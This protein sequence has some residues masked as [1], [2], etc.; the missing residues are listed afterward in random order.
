MLSVQEGNKKKHGRINQED[1]CY[2]L[3]GWCLMGERWCVN[4]AVCVLPLTHWQARALEETC[5]HHD[6]AGLAAESKLLPRFSFGGAFFLSLQ[7]FGPFSPSSPPLA[8]PTCSFPVPS[9]LKG[10]SRCTHASPIFLSPFSL[11]W[12]LPV[13]VQRHHLIPFMFLSFPTWILTES[14]SWYI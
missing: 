3:L 6:G 14:S 11:P 5:W 1:V 10:T 13:L 9:F 7:C 8:C 12:P 2:K 4:K